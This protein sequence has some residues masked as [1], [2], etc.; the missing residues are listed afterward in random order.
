[1]SSGFTRTRDAQNSGA[2]RSVPTTLTWATPANGRARAEHVG[3]G[4]PSNGEI[5]RYKTRARLE[6]EPHVCGECL[7][8]VA[9]IPQDC[10][11]GV[12]P[13]LGGASIIRFWSTY[14]LGAGR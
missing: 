4:R 13:G 2:G 7:E 5:L 1:M 3:A 14:G 8:F 6:V 11:V 12:S 9:Q 10:P